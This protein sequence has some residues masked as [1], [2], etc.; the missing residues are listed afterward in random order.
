[1]KEKENEKRQYETKRQREKR[2]YIALKEE[3]KNRQRDTSIEEVYTK[4]RIKHYQNFVK[5]KNVCFLQSQNLI[6]LIPEN[7]PSSSCLTAT[8]IKSAFPQVKVT[9]LKES[10]KHMQSK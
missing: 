7:L 6:P 2:E 1:M 4:V 8:K 5:N 9:K 10:M 3:R